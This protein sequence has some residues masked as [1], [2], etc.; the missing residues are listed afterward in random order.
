LNETTPGN[1]EETSEKRG[2]SDSWIWGI[3]LIA[4]G[5]LFLLQAVTQFRL[6]SWWAVL[7]LIPAIGSFA[8][9]WR[10]FQTSRQIDNGVRSSLFGG[11]IFLIVAGIFL[12]N[13]DLSRLWPVLVVA[14]GLAVLANALFPE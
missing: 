5:G 1:T 3:A 14:A 12:F 13:Y 4:L 2:R 6:I 8:S 7:I 11:T 10:R 9:A